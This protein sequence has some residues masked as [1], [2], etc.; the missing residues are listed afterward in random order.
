MKKWNV[1][2]KSF[3]FDEII[4][5][6]K[7]I[8]NNEFVIYYRENNY[9]KNRFGITVPKK[10]GKAVIRNYYKRIIRNICD[11]YNFC[12]SNY[13]DYIIIMR[14]RCID[15]PYNEISESF[16]SLIKKIEKE[17]NYEKTN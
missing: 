6:G 8:K 2:K 11:K 5:D 3:E 1:I 14:K 15:I 16:M 7:S 17:T 12:Y 9:Q 13:K 10:I 4:K